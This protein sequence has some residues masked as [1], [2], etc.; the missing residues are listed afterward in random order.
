MIAISFSVLSVVACSFLI[1]VFVH[2]HRELMR[3]K[4]S[5]DKL[6]MTEVDVRRIEAGLM[7]ARTA[8]HADMGQ[9]ARTTAAMQREILL[10]GKA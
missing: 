7:L 4:K 10:G 9:R 1:Y 3:L 5:A 6:R 8:S 2:F